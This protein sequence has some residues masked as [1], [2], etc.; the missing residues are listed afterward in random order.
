MF[1][2]D[3]RDAVHK[4]KNLM[5][6]VLRG[7][8]EQEFEP[9]FQPQ[10]DAS[11]GEIVGIEALARWHHPVM[12]TVPP[13]V[14]LEPLAASG[15]MAELDL[16]ILE[17]AATEVRRLRSRGLSVPELAVNIGLSQLHDAAIL[18]AV[19]NL[20]PLPCR[21]TF[22]ILESALFDDSNLTERM[23]LDRMR[24]NGLGIAIDDFG[25]GHGSIHALTSV[26]PDKLKIDKQMIRPVSQSEDH[27]VVLESVLGMARK[28]GIETVA[29]GVETYEDV[30]LLAEMGVDTLQG[31]YFASPMSA[32]QLE[33]YLTVHRQAPQKC[34]A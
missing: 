2:R 28:L 6:D 15:R 16:Q 31:Y 20:D 21:L 9:Y 13:K 8:E 33:H 11:T 14:F 1:G 30:R 32:R 22:E 26:R 4:Q 19:D 12:G 34:S 10:H 29:E 3:M 23:T 5:D 25:T 17:M 27:R 7:L 24:E 18:R